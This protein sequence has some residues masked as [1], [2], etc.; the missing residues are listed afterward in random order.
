MVI[1][2]TG[3]QKLGRRM[4]PELHKFIL[5]KFNLRVRKTNTKKKNFFNFSFFDKISVID[6]F[7]TG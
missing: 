7:L 4:L 3:Q 6:L 2:N 1:N 5:T